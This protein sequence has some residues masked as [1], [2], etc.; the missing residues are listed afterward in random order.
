MYEVSFCQIEG[1][2]AKYWCEMRN[3]MKPLKHLNT[4]WVVPVKEVTA[5]SW[6]ALL[7]DIQ[8]VWVCSCT[9]G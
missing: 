8:S 4:F 1:T 3:C 6:L 9:K 5:L 2:N 7:P